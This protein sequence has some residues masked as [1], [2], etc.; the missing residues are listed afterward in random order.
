MTIFVVEIETTQPLEQPRHS[1]QAIWSFTLGLF[2]VGCIWLL[3]AIPAI[4]LGVLALSK[5]AESKRPQKGRCLAISGIVLGVIGIFVGMFPPGAII[6]FMLISSV[7][8]TSRNALEGSIKRIS[9]IERV[10]QACEDYAT[11]NNGQFPPGLDQLVENGY[12]ETQEMLLWN[13]EEKN[14]SRRKQLLYRPG[15]ARSATEREIL[16]S[17]PVPELF[18]RVVSFTDG[19]VEMIPD[20]Q[21]LNDYAASFIQR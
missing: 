1:P 6:S 20:G 18:L 11:D 17:A 8:N 7:S 5:I 10:V 4:I 19:K 13:P 9:G 12:L 3:G 2:G 14:P 15:L 16:I 21:F